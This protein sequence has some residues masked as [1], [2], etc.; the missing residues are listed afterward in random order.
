MITAIVLTCVGLAPDGSLPVVEPSIDVGAKVM[1][2]LYAI[3]NQHQRDGLAGLALAGVSE[4]ARASSKPPGGSGSSTSHRII[5]ASCASDGLDQSTPWPTQ[6]DKYNAIRPAY[7]FSVLNALPAAPPDTRT[8]RHADQSPHPPPP[9][10]PTRQRPPLAQTGNAV[11]PQATSSTWKTC[12]DNS[13]LHVRQ[14]PA[15]PT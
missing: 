9:T 5:A 3:H 13:Q 10:A 12:L 4:L 14:G 15:D 1:G 2:L 6:Y 11:A 8:P 7:V